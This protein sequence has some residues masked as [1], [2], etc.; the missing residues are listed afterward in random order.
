MTR[1][2]NPGRWMAGWLAG[3][4]VGRLAGWP[5]GRV[6]GWPGGRVARPWPGRGRAVAGPWPGWPATKKKSVHHMVLAQLLSFSPGTL[7]DAGTD[8]R[9][10]KLPRQGSR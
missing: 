8:G 3:W 7:K 10:E 2:K 4:P 9:T 1:F 5:A 6:A